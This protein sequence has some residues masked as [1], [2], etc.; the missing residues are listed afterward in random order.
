MEESDNKSKEEELNELR[1]RV[2][3]L[4][5][6][7]GQ[8]TDDERWRQTGYY[9]AYFATAGFFLGGLAAVTSLMFN[10]I[11]S[12][13]AGDPPLQIVQIYLTFPLGE[14]A[15]TMDSGIA[16]AVGCCL[17]IGTGMVL[18]V[19]FYLL[20]TRFTKESK[21]VARFAFGAVL[22]ISMWL[23]HYYAILAW[24]QPLLFDGNWIVDMIP[25]WVAAATHLVFGWT[26][27]L[28]YP[29]GLYKPYRL[30]TEQQ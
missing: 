20:L 6:E 30:Q 3:E 18:G 27:V 28:L 21:L 29:F 9:T 17:Y 16:L 25:W 24:V 2:A 4:E 10:I 23:V 5:S 12:A 11:G 19:P 26:M 1:S 14:K 7:V 22:A 8:P 15:L 13:I